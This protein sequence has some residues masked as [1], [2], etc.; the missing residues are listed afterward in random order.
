MGATPAGKE[1]LHMNRNGVGEFSYAIE[2][3]KAIHHA[4]TPGANLDAMNRVAVQKVSEFLDTLASNSPTTLKMY[5]WVRRNIAWATTEAVYGPKNPFR[6][7]EILAAFWRFEPGIVILLLQ[8][9]P[10]ILAKESLQ[11][12]EQVVKAFT[13]YFASGGHEHGS[14]LVRA[15]YQHS[16]D[17]N[18][19]IEDIARFEL[20]GASAVLM[21]T[22]P[23]AFWVLWHVVSDST[24]LEECRDELHRLCKIE[25]DTVTLDI[26][27]VKTSCP[28]L[29]ST[30]REVL[31][32]HG[33]GISVR[34]VQQD[35]LLD[36][37]YLLKKGSTLMIPAPVQHSSTVAYGDNATEFH[38]KRFVRAEG[39]RLNPVAFRGFGGG[40]TLCPGRDFASTEIIAFVA[41][42]ILRFDI[43]PVSGDWVRPTTDKAGMQATVLPPD[44]DVEI[45][46]TLRE[47]Q[48]AGKQWNAILTG[49]EKPVQLMAEDL[50]QG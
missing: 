46:V 6:D 19:S 41:L 12:R 33:A 30:L 14:A 10:S 7:S 8:L 45:K 32:H 17:Y 50:N 5:D 40:S 43:T 31:R 22:L 36:G 27:K 1:I 13:D 39:K 23:C 44:A 21:N 18:V 26:T 24:A 16:A 25:D 48:F 38:Y 29:L 20:G 2:F 11:A 15:R 37:K 34:V 47:D 4:V 49:S 9:F 35:H 42:M 28:I 3:D